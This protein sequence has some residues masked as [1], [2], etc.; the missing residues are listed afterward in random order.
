MRPSELH[1]HRP[2]VD[3]PSEQGLEVTHA[4]VP[5]THGL[6]RNPW[7]FLGKHPSAPTFVGKGREPSRARQTLSP[8]N[9]AGSGPLGP[10]LLLLAV[11]KLWPVYIKSCFL[12]SN[13]SLPCNEADPAR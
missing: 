9:P 8:L 6:S 2:G 13:P 1:L 10:P 7:L 4:H 11:Q 3:P 12:P 5:E